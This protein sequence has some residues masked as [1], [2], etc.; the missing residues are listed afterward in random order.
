MQRNHCYKRP[1]SRQQF[2]EIIRCQSADNHIHVLSLSVSSCR[3]FQAGTDH[4]QLAR[5]CIRIW[6]KA[7]IV[8]QQINKWTTSE[9][10][11][12]AS[13]LWYKQIA[14]VNFRPRDRPQPS[15]SSTIEW[16]RAPLVDDAD[17]A[18]RHSTICRRITDD[19]LGQSTCRCVHEYRETQAAFNMSPTWQ[20]K[21]IVSST[22]IRHR[23]RAYI[24]RCRHIPSSLW[25]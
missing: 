5:A 25:K 3:Q 21:S 23:T 24:I 11:H 6:K 9:E 16:R 19:S 20:Y 15:S 8:A 14:G 22:C 10:R 18:D 2:G 1:Y 7:T 12:H 4:Y 13:R 17:A